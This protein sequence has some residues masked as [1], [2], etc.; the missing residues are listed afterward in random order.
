[1]RRAQRTPLGEAVGPP[2]PG[3]RLGLVL[4]GTLLVQEFMILLKS[5]V[6]SL[7]HRTTVTITKDTQSDRAGFD[8]SGLV[9]P[10]LFLS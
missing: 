6:T 5:K 7:R 1:M 8:F 9:R 10:H 3:E 4:W 2:I